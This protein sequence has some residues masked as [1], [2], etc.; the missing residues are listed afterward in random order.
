MVKENNSKKTLDLD[1]V[2]TNELGEFGKFQIVNLLLVCFP[3]LVAAFP[4]DYIFSVAAIPHRCRIPECGEENKQQ[5]FSPDWISNAIP[6]S[7]S[8]LA[9]CE[10][11]LPHSIFDHNQTV[12]CDDFVYARD[13][14]AVYD[15]NLGCQE[16]LRVLVGTLGNVGTLLVLPFTGFISDRFGRRLALVIS[17]FNIALFGLIRA[18][19]TSYTM[20]IIT[21]IIQTTLG[22]GIYS[23]AYIYGAELVGPNYRV[24]ATTVIGLL[25]S[26]GLVLL[27]MLA[28]VI[29]QWRILLMVLYIPPFLLISYYWLLPESVRWLIS[30]KKF[31][32]ARKVLENVARINKTKISEESL[33]ALLDSPQSVAAENDNIGV[34]LKVIRSRVLLQ[35]GC[36]TPIWWITATFVYYGLSIN[37]T[38]LSD[39][40]Y[41]NYILTMTSIELPGGICVIFALNWWGRKKTLFL[42]YILCGICNIV[43]VFVPTDMY[44]LRLIIYL[45]GKFCI[46]AVL[47]AVYLYTSELYPTE[48]RHTLLAFSSMIGRLGSILAPLTPVLSL[49]WHGIP[50]LMFGVMGLI[51]GLLVLTQPET[52]NTRLPDTLAEAEAL[53]TE[54]KIS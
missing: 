15:F 35:R 10:R 28:W 7:G 3:L 17:A 11:F 45:L 5:F 32:D 19:S 13:N 33:K 9:S 36:T 26:V 34:F 6:E 38:S 4:S 51:S 25:F 18:F 54:T 2:L 49:Y 20:L 27:G 22:G 14:S 41:L 37:S 8:G 23:S 12:G 48:Y 39:T 47:A 40:M 52:Q 31:L 44:V 21:Q 42:G 43:F 29:Q 30:K 24:S 16:W 50:S 53:G 46:S 1:E